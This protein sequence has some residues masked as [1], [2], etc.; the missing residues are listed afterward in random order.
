LDADVDT[1]RLNARYQVALQNYVYE[2]QVYW[3]RIS[4]FVLLNSALL[5]ARNALPAGPADG[6]IRLGTGLLG[7]IATLTWAHTAARAHH[8]NAF[9]LGLLAELEG[10]LGNADSAPFTRRARYLAGQPVRLA[11]GRGLQLP[12]YAR[13]NV[14]DTTSAILTVVFAGLWVVSV[15]HGL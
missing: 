7:I 11:G 6:A 9:W 10:Q 14:N 12:W 1:A 3:T 2:G 8:V 13:G 4:A 15:I 5:V